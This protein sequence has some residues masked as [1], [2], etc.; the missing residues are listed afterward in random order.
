MEQGRSLRM[1]I[2]L[3]LGAI[4]CAAT[5][6]VGLNVLQRRSETAAP[7]VAAG[8]PAGASQ[9]VLVDSVPITLNPDPSQLVYFPFEQPGG[10]VP[11]VVQPTPGLPL[12]SATFVLAPPQPTVP[13][14]PTASPDPVIF[15]SYIVQQGDT[16]YGIAQA[17]NSA[18]E[19]MALHGIDDNDLAPGATLNLPVANPAFCPGNRPYV[20]REHDTV[21]DI[22]AAHNTTA[23]VLQALNGLDAEY[24]IETAQVV[25]VPG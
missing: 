18:I 16:L 22:A 15:I 14:A 5:S 8:P 12:A 25:C 11:E 6:L 2:F 9:Q 4:I 20:V 19:L 17:Q 10:A 21:F 24:S 3:V 1:I 7:T 23:A 13:L